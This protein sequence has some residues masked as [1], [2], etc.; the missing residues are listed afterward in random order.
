MVIA[1][2]GPRLARVAD[3][4]ADR[5]GIGEAVAGALLL[6]AATSLSGIVTT[7][8]GAADGD[9][10]FAV[11]NALGGIAVQTLF[12]SVADL[13]L[14]RVNL[15]HYAASLPN[16]LNATLLLTLLSLVLLAVAG[17]GVEAVRIHPVSV[18]LV[19]VYLYGLRVARRAHAVP[20]W[21]PEETEQTVVDRPEESDDREPLRRLWLRFAGSAAVLAAAGWVIGRGGLSIVSESG[22]SGTEVA[23]LL[24]G[25]VTSSPELIVLLAAVRMGSPTLGIGNIIGGNAFDVMFVPVADVFFRSGSIYQAVDAETVF[26][27]GLTLS[28]TAVFTA[29]LLSRQ[30]KGIGFEGTAI[31]ALYAI[32]VVTLLTGF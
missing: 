30:R 28:M 20:M 10:G 32:G 22:F 8:V 26:V 19:T 5:T 11:S 29:G 23:T 4:L 12:I 14:R 7:G 9:G 24:T 6:G 2:V 13:L 18:V 17:P 1:I 31:L 25:V 15:E 3:R 27:L 16:V 21:R